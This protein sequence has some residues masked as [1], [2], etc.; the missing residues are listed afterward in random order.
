MASNEVGGRRGVR[1][2]DETL[3]CLGEPICDRLWKGH[4]VVCGDGWPIG[5]DVEIGEIIRPWGAAA[6]RPA[7]IALGSLGVGGEG[8]PPGELNEKLKDM[9]RRPT[10]R[11]H[12]TRA[13]K[14][15]I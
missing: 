9:S 5:E 15:Q 10:R 11:G 7:L 14:I 1:D 8:M 2:V 12:G 4:G 13:E 6:T 3:A